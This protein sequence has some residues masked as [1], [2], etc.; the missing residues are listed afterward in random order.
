MS[1]TLQCG[2]GKKDGINCEL[3]GELEIRELHDSFIHWDTKGDDTS[4][5]RNLYPTLNL[6]ISNI[7]GRVED[8]EFCC[9]CF[10]TLIIIILLLLVLLLIN[11]V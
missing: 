4:A 5:S 6:T 7:N 2:G 11:T 3:R 8:A 9:Y 1:S 10:F